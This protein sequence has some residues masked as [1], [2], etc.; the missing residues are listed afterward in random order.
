MENGRRRSLLLIAAVMMVALCGQGLFAAGTAEK[1]SGNLKTLTCDNREFDSLLI[2]GIDSYEIALSDDFAVSLTGDDNLVEKV[3]IVQRGS[4]L[5]VVLPEAH[6]YAPSELTAR[7][8]IPFLDK[9]EVEAKSHGV[10][11]GVPVPGDMQ[12]AVAGGSSLELENLILDHGDIEISGDSVLSGKI[13]ADELSMRIYSSEVEFSGE[14]DSLSVFND[15]GTVTLDEVFIGGALLAFHH[16]GTGSC[17]FKEAYAGR[18]ASTTVV[19]LY[20]DSALTL[21]TEGSVA[22]YVYDDAEL[23]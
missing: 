16:G 20:D 13:G 6:R 3:E 17:S 4:V 11:K 14:A 21:A 23:N 12:I 18:I 5:S 19:K 7:I 2:S 8:E 9:L 10:L 1:G 15:G 22:D